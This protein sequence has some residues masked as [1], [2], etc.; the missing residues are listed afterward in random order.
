MG[1]FLFANWTSSIMKERSGVMSD[2]IIRKPSFMR[3][4]DDAIAY[5]E[6]A[7]KY[8]GI[9]SDSKRHLSGEERDEYKMK[10]A[11]SMRKAAKNAGFLT[12]SDFCKWGG[13]HLAAN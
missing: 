9:M 5:M 6:C 10:F 1:S 4:M 3:N 8:M 7:K 12:V 11:Y 2:I 13:K